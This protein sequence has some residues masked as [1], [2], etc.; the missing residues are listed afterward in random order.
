MSLEEFGNMT[1]AQ[2][3][4][5]LANIPKIERLFAGQSKGSGSRDEVDEIMD[6]A[7]RFGLIPPTRR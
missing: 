2:F 1:I 6:D 3:Y 4:T 5:S 7:K